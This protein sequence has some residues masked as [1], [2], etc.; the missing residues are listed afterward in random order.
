MP[1]SFVF[2]D[3]IRDI[4]GPDEVPPDDDG[5]LFRIWA[6]TPKYR[7]AISGVMLDTAVLF[8]TVM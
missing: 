1:F 6:F 4:D 8:H 5:L 2:G 3:I 7:T